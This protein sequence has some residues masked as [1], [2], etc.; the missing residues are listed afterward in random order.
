MLTPN[1]YVNCSDTQ[2]CLLANYFTT[3]NFPHLRD[4]SVQLKGATS[5]N[6]LELMGQA[7]QLPDLENFILQEISS[8][9]GPLITPQ[10]AREIERPCSAAVQAFQVS[11]YTR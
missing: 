4:L 7:M 6:I 2:P 3:R 8:H 1:V 5:R 9:V 11:L 10:E